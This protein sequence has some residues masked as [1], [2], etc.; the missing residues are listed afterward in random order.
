MNLYVTDVGNGTIS[1]VVIATGVATTLVGAGSST[2]PYGITTD[3]MNLFVTDVG[4]GTISKI[5]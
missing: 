2:N 3:G 1:K 4:K 5:L